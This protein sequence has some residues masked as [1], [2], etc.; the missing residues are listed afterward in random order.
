VITIRLAYN[1]DYPGHPCAWV[2]G[3]PVCDH[4]EEAFLLRMFGVEGQG[5][6]GLFDK[7]GARRV[8]DGAEHEAIEF[9]L[10]VKR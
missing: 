6:R 1:G 5:L 2:N 10:E 8:G 7:L 3:R 4:K 9:Q